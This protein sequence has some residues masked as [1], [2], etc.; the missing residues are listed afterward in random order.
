MAETNRKRIGFLMNN[1]DLGVVYY[2]S[3]IVQSLHYLEDI[4]KPFIV[5]FYDSSTEKY[6]NIFNTYPYIQPIQLDYPHV[7]K[8]YFWSFIKRENYFINNLLS[9]YQLEAALPV[10]DILF[11]SP[12]KGKKTVAWVTDFQHKFYP[13][14]FGTFNRIIREFRFKNSFKNTNHVILSSNDAKSHLLRFYSQINAQ[15]HVLNFVSHANKIDCPD[16]ETIKLKYDIQKP[17]FIVSNQFYRH[18]NHLVVLES[19]K[20]LLDQGYTD[21]NIVFTGKKEDYRDKTFY[22]K[23]EKYIEDNKLQSNI[24]ILGVI[25]RNEQL[26]LFKK[27]IATIQPSF[28]E[29]WNTS[30]EDAK[31]L[32]QQ[33]ICS[34]I[35]VHHEQMGDKAFY[36]NPNDSTS[37]A[38]ILIKLLTKETQPLPIFDDFEQR[39]NQFAIGF[40]N[41]F[42]EN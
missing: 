10:N 13:H 36:F 19:V 28:F 24:K 23:I 21:F 37:L 34:D 1:D 42:D 5:L 18:K 16:G 40:I 8:L 39:V 29:G 31:T 9:Q 27:A 14:F 32:Q 3:N 33:V 6:I 4:K 15:L 17:Y 30:I 25:P 20:H 12:I 7:L 41:I 26:A 11:K 38:S 35:P 22:P 2:L